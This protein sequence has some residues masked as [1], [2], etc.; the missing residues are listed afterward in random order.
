MVFE[1]GDVSSHRLGS[2]TQYVHNR[3]KTTVNE[4]ALTEIKWGD[5]HEHNFEEWL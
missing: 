2:E 5:S 1:W 3:S 4:E